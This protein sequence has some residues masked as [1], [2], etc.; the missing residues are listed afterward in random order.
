MKVNLANGGQDP[1]VRQRIIDAAIRA[2]DQ[3]GEASVRISAVAQEAEVTQGMI[4]YHF[5]GREGLIQEAQLARF[6]STVNQD[7]K[8]LED[9]A[10]KVPSVEELLSSLAVLTSEIV[11]LRRS[12]ARATRLMAIGAAMPRPELLS[13]ISDAQTTLI[14]GMEKVILIAQARDL[15]RNDLN[16]RA[17]AAFVLSYNTGL[18]VADIDTQRPNEEHLSQVIAG[19]IDTLVVRP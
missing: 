5:G 9:T 1:S 6:L 17:I 16:P 14:D 19:F 13:L 18:V 3:G 4:S 2:I 7:I 15:M 10:R 12:A 11:S 8:A